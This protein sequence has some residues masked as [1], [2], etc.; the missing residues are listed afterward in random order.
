VPVTIPQPFI[1]NSEGDAPQWLE[2]VKTI[3]TAVVTAAITLLGVWVTLRQN[4]GAL[5]LQPRVSKLAFNEK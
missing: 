3:P 2:Y 1:M 4:R 5:A